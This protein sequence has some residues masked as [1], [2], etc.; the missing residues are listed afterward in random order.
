MKK[1]A[2]IITITEA[3]SITR[4]NRKTGKDYIFERME[5]PSRFNNEAVSVFIIT[6][7]GYIKGKYLNPKMTCKSCADIKP[8]HIPVTCIWDGLDCS[9]I[10]II[11]NLTLHKYFKENNVFDNFDIEYSFSEEIKNKNYKFN[12]NTIKYGN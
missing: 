6:G 9:Y 12:Y 1:T 10:F 4:W 11:N 3:Y 2:F 5:I 7:G 8:I